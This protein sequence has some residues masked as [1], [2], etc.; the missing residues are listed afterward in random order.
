MNR[1]DGRGRY[2]SDLDKFYGRKLGFFGFSLSLHIFDLLGLDD[3]PFFV[4]EIFSS[5]RKFKPVN[6]GES[7][8]F[9]F[10]FS[11]VGDLRRSIFYQ[12]F[13]I[14]RTKMKACGIAIKYGVSQREVHRGLNSVGYVQPGGW[15]RRVKFRGYYES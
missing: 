12:A 1:F 3:A 8:G 5:L 4:S 15:S 13:A 9:T 2:G 14:D 6:C 11:G 7:S 10:Y